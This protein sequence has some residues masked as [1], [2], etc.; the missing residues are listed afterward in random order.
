MWGVLTGATVAAMRKMFARVSLVLLVVGCGDDGGDSVKVDGAVP[1]DAARLDGPAVDGPV[2]LPDASTIDAP[3]STVVEVPCAGA[4]IA[5]EV[6][7]PG[8]LFVVTDTM[9]P[10][11][12]I[13]RFT[14]P[15]SHS[16]VSGTALPGDGRF[17]VG[18]SQ[19]KCLRFTAV[20]GYPF[21]CD[22]HGFSAAI[23]VQP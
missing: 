2:V 8:F 15:A 22:P 5:S 18:F 20:G 9:V 17:I 10:V 7:A 21:V 19:T 23:T 4:T 11:N 12:S 16:A 13:V 1:I 6:T 14:M 3:P